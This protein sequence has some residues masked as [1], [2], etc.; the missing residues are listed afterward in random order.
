MGVAIK[1]SGVPREELYSWSCFPARFYNRQML[2]TDLYQ[3]QQ[4]SD[5]DSRT[6]RGLSRAS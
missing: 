6:L 1:E 5:L 4:R 3:S 2:I